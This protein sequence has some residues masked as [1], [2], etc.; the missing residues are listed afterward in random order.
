MEYPL[1]VH[2]SFVP[3]GKIV[4]HNDRDLVRAIK[5]A[6]DSSPTREALITQTENTRAVSKEK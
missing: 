3:G 6:M 4:A 2:L 5:K 1:Y